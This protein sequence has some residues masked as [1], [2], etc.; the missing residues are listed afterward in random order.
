MPNAVR[1][2]ESHAVATERF[3]GGR[4]KGSMVRTH[5]DWVRD[6][7]DRSE[8]IAFFEAIP[9]SM[10]SVLLSSWYPFEDAIALDR[11]IMNRFGRGEL[12]FLQ[13]VGAYSARQ[14]L[15][16]LYRFMRRDGIHGFLRRS[17]LLHEEVQDF[18]GATY[19]ELSATEGRMVHERYDSYSPLHCSSAI[20]FYRECIR[21]HGGM[22]VDVWES[23]CQCRGEVS[24]TFETAWA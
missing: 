2:I 1:K 5:V 15:T 21:L 22:E 17:A 20:G 9:A 18:G 19:V 6:H 4:V 7:A 14:Y 12:R 10:R 8:V 13:H 24:C 16:S 11:V 3:S 23:Q